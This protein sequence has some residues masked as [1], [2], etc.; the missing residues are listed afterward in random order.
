MAEKQLSLFDA[1]AAREYQRKQEDAEH[2]SLLLKHLGRK[3]A[4][5]WHD[6][7]AKLAAELNAAYKTPLTAEMHAALDR[8][9]ARILAKTKPL[10]DKYALLGIEPGA[11]KRDI[12]NAYRRKARKLHPDV[13]G[14]AESFKQLHETYRFLLKQA[15]D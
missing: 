11:T 8:A 9:R 14:D 15:Q 12:K 1:P 5:R 3:G 10:S 7:D 6:N 13:G 2:E 4:K